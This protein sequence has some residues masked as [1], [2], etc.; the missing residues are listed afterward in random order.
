M[1]YEIAGSPQL[2]IWHSDSV[3]GLDPNS[4]EVY[5]SEPF[6]ATFAMSIGIPQFVND[7]IFVMS[8]NRKSARIGI[9]EDGRS[10]STLWQGD[11]KTGVGGVFNTAVIR[12]DFIYACGQNG[13]YMCVRL[14]SG[15]R[16]WSTFGPSTGKRPAAWAN[17]FTVP[18]KD[19]YFH[20]NDLGDLIIAKMSP[21]GYQEVSRTHLIE[22]THDIGNRKVVWSHPAFANQSVYVRN[23]KQIRCFSLAR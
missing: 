23:D 1:I 9:A 2:I 21:A 18:H 15:E 10:A 8:F 20:A 4:G 3:N 7:S 16:V 5:W 17:V 12:D 13:R 22:P 11:T 6:E 14:D 19:R